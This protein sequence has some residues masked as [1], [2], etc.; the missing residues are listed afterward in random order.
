MSESRYRL[1]HWTEKAVFIHLL[2]LILASGWIF[3]GNIWWMRN[4]LSVWA[5]L[6]VVLTLVVMLRSGTVGREARR[7]VWWLLPWLLFIGLVAASAFNPSFRPIKLEGETLLVHFGAPY[8]HLPSTVDPERSLRTLW[9]GAAV[10][11]SA[12]NLLLIP[13]SRRW[14]RQ[15]LS[16]GAISCLLLAVF[17]TLQKLLQ[18]GYYFGSTQS[19][20]ARYFGTFIYNNHWGAFMILWLAASGGLLFYHVR[21]HRGRDLWHSPFSLFVVGFLFIAATGPV[22]ASRAA[23]AMALLVLG[24]TAGHAMWQIAAARRRAQ[25]SVILYLGL[26]ALLVASIVG[27]TGWLA[28]RSINERYAETKAVL[29][30]QQSLWTGRMELYRDTWELASRK[31]VF[32]WGLD[33][34]AAAFRLIQPRPLQAHRQYELSYANAHSDWLQSL[35]ETGFFGT[36][37]LVLMALV[38]LLAGWSRRNWTVISGYALTGCALVALYAWI[39]F[40]FANAAVMISFW[41]MFFA[42]IRHAELQPS[43]TATPTS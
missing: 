1:H 33:S 9:F 14:F 37:L 43:T 41:L 27:A 6:S 39:E 23:T 17:G 34:Y 2:L 40:P 26:F 18:A 24:L 30:G 25:R 28:Q 29:T 16:V 22:S 21:N 38:P 12:F 10:Y 8:P 20:N 4:A 36:T 5:S 13:Q 32:G 3:G 11:L 15:F 7:R 35:A 31:P 19:P 42:A